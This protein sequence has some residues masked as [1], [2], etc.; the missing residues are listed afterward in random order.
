MPH[1]VP[2]RN[3]GKGA[4]KQLHVTC[5]SCLLDRMNV[6]TDHKTLCI[7]ALR[8]L[9]IACDASE[10]SCFGTLS[11]CWQFNCG[12]IMI[13]HIMWPCLFKAR[14][15]WHHSCLLA[16]AII[17]NWMVLAF[18]MC[19]FNT[20][21][22]S[23]RHSCQVDSQ[24]CIGSHH[25]FGPTLHTELAESA[26]ME[27]HALT[28]CPNL[29]HACHLASCMLT[30]AP[31]FLECFVLHH[32]LLYMPPSSR[33]AQHTCRLQYWVSHTC[34]M[35]LSDVL[36]WSIGKDLLP[37]SSTKRLFLLTSAA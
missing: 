37:S 31:W 7:N 24:L 33:W 17:L 16:R 23:C 29:S 27:K 6:I 10:P 20:A 25:I 21:T 1:S 34:K 12:A 3:S 22:E 4:C 19:L 18:C 26:V 14:Q 11:W 15:D 35:V 9:E 8:G 36:P 2:T 13:L 30:G 32:H 5:R 28:H